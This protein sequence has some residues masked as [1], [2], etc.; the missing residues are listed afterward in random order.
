MSLGTRG[1]GK[2]EDTGEHEGEQ[3]GGGGCAGGRAEPPGRGLPTSEVQ[4]AYGG[5]WAPLPRV[6]P[7]G[8][9]QH[10]LCTIASLSHVKSWWLP[11]SR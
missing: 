4:Q 1:R 2:R 5:Q 3:G 7:Y 11:M 10:L 9:L 6:G 8:S